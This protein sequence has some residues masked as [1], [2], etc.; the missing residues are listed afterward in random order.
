M[1]SPPHRDCSPAKNPT[2]HE[3]FDNQECSMPSQSVRQNCNPGF[4]GY[5]KVTGD[6]N[7]SRPLDRCTREV[8]IQFCIPSVLSLQENKA[9][10]RTQFSI[11]SSSSDLHINM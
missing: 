5:K 9:T 2:L 11:P 7:G 3:H 6:K 8:T 10:D 4:L 1:L